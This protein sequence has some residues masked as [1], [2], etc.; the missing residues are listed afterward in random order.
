MT[1]A[2]TLA[3][4]VLLLFNVQVA[5]F[6]VIVVSVPGAEIPVPCMRMLREALFSTGH[7]RLL[8]GTVIVNDAPLDAE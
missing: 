7:A 4:D 3:I 1:V 5:G 2:G 8:S 6:S